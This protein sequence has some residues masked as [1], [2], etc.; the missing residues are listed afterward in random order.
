MS[1]KSKAASKQ[2]NLDKKRAIKSAR[3]AQYQAW[4]EAGQ[5]SKSKRAVKASKRRK[6]VHP[7]SHPYGPCGNIGCKKCDPCNIHGTKQA[8]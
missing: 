2:K 3:R 4:A 8:A 5:N 7:I 1:K 6:K